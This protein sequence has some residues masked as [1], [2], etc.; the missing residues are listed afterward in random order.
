MGEKVIAS[1]G[2]SPRSPQAQ[3]GSCR[4]LQPEKGGEMK[5]FLEGAPVT[6]LR[7]WCTLAACPTKG[8]RGLLEGSTGAL[9]MDRDTL[10]GPVSAM[11]TR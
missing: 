3:R 10:R 4:S 1:R 11:K 8:R 2:C 6:G 7:S 5:P 9:Q